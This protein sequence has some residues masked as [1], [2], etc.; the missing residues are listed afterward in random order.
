M[1]EPKGAEQLDRELLRIALVT[2]TLPPATRTNTY[3]LGRKHVC[4]IDPA[5]VDASEQAELLMT[6]R[7]LEGHGAHVSA[8]VLTHHHPDHVGAAVFLWGHL[9]APILAHPETATRLPFATQG[10]LEDG[11]SLPC[12]GPDWTVVDTPGHAPGHVALFRRVDRAVI[13]GDMVAGVGTILVD[14]REGSMSRYMASLQRLR[15]L[16]PDVLFPAHGPQL[17]NGTACLEHY[18]A[19]RKARADAVL[20]RLHAGDR[21][22]QSMV[23]HI[24]QDTPVTMHALAARSVLSILIQHQEEGRASVD[25]DGHW[26]PVR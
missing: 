24:Y 20:Q 2:P 15:N 7:E 25:P 18:I 22:P 11:Q 17:E 21:S 6:I 9:G 12:D 1:D 5:P 13:A 14:P 3:V 16:N 26:R 23:P 4:I 8:L 10:P 19:H